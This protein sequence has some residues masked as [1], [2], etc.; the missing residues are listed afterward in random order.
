MLSL[1]YNIILFLLGLL[2]LPKFLWQ[3]FRYGKYRHS[4]AQRLGKHLPL[5]HEKQGPVFWLHMCSV[6]ETKALIPLYR[7]LREELPQAHFFISSITETGHAEALKNLK[8]AEA[9]FYLPLDFSFLMKKLVKRLSPDFLILSESEFWYHLLKYVKKSGGKSILVNGKISE[10]S[11]YLFKK[12]SFFS[13]RLFNYFDHLMVQNQ[14]YY[15]RFLPFV[16]P[17][18]LSICGNLKL[19]IRFIPMSPSE[20]MQFQNQLGIKPEDIVITIGSTHAPEEKEILSALNPLFEEFP[21][22]KILIAPRHPERWNPV[23]H[24]LSAHYLLSRYSQKNPSQEARV[25]LIDTLGSLMSCFQI[26]ALAIIGG[27]FFVG[28][29]GHNIFEPLQADTP[30]LF[31][32]HMESQTELVELVLKAQAGKAVILKDLCSEVRNLLNHPAKLNQMK[33]QAHLVVKKAQGATGRVFEELKN[34]FCW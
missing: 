25:I 33:Q 8:G 16:E 26:S 14:I 9:Y 15:D 20:K 19:D 5:L 28:V 18:R 24:D 21:H 32:P 2:V 31:G 27:S 12:F 3:R 10:K 30:V 23:A 29:G 6:G 4:I 1:F 13:K 34:L 7:K 11:A 22:L 17:A